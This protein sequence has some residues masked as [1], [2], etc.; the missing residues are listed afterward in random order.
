MNRM[1]SNAAM[2]AT[3]L[4]LYIF[5]SKNV[6]EVRWALFFGAML[7]MVFAYSLATMNSIIDEGER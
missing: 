5:I 1:F 3:F 7:G 6:G 2:Y 4:V